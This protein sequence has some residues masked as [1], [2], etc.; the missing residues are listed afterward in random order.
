MSN[1][2]LVEVTR[3]GRVESRHRGAAVV[4][5]PEGASVFAIGNVDAPVF[6]RSAV[7]AIQALPL[8]ETG[9]ADTFGFGARELAL[10]QASHGGEPPHVAGV[11][12]MLQ[13]IG[14]GEGDLECGAHMPSHA[15]SARALIAE[16]REAGQ[17]HNNCSGKHANFLAV[18]RRLGVDHQGYI[19]ARHPVQELVRAALENLIGAA[20]DPEH[21]GIDGCSIPTYA[22]PLTALARGFAR[23]ASGSGLAAERATAARRLY[24]AA[25]R[26]PY[27]IAGTGRFCTE[28]MQL[29]GGAAL[30]KTGAEGVFCAAIPSRGLGVALKC[31]DGTTRASEAMMA[32][33]LAGLFVEQAEALRRWTQAPVVTRRNAPVGEVR[34]V[35][36]AFATLRRSGVSAAASVC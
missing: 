31:E 1:P 36:E 28:V 20:H 26:E 32:A 19:A 22:V 11:S 7:K 10:S 16:G 8:I 2:V 23:F 3:G 15:A 30:L 24:D 13:A 33:L 21:C 18:A 12:A 9:A 34:A 6:P 35:A 17:L 4:A 29:L 5:D 14:L 25:V 27:F